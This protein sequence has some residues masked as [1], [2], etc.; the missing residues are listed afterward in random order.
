MSRQ[1]HVAAAFQHPELVGQRPWRS[2]EV[3]LGDHVEDH[4]TGGG[5]VDLLG[6]EGRTRRPMPRS[7]GQAPVTNST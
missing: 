3:G 2:A 4:L 1:H 6:A 5:H 7:S